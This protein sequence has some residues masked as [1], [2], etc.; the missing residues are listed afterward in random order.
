M[1][2]SFQPGDETAILA[3]M[4][5]SLELGEF[6]GTTRH[7]LRRSV[8]RLPG[9]PEGTAVAVEGGRVVGYV[10]PSHDDLTVDAGF[11]RRGHGRRL[12]AAGLRIAGTAG[13]DHLQLY[14]E[15]GRP[16]VQAFLDALGFRYRSSLWLFQ[17]PADRAVRGP[18]FPSDLEIRPFRPV[19]DDPRYVELLNAAFAD[20]PT[21]LSV[22]LE[23]VRFV[24]AL[25]DF[26]PSG[27]LLL[28][29]PGGEPVAFAKAEMAEADDGEPTGYVGFLGVLPARR[30]QGLGRELLRWAV[31]WARERGAGLVEL[32][33]ES[34]NDRALDLYRGEGFEPVV[35]WPHWVIPTGR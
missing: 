28:A 26:D 4:E 31:G 9:N 29:P 23:R 3:I 33:V 32:Q 12:V 35:E 14:G 19:E 24:H 27:I 30:R 15:H 21:P 8:D 20:H 25:P 13:L 34:S 10:T 11:R 18:A 22:T 7:D 5:R 16:E 6:P 17:L 1:I 2:R